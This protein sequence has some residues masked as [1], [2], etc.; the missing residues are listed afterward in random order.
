MS[1]LIE[2]VEK[3]YEQ[4]KQKRREEIDLNDQISELI[5]RYLLDNIQELKFS[6]YDKTNLVCH[7]CEL[8]YVIA[9]LAAR[10]FI[11]LTYTIDGNVFEI[12]L[13]YDDKEPRIII[14]F[15]DIEKYNNFIQQYKVN[16]IEY[17]K[18]DQDLLEALRNC[19]P[20]IL[21]PTL[22]KFG[23]SL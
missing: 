6:R 14:R 2:Q 10:V 7:K 19:D 13:D 16:I 23:I 1:E 15:D 11:C 17:P 5:I 21:E 4:I 3:I 9:N 22:R 8:V 12:T 20:V 18:I